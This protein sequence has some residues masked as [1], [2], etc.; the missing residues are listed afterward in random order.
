MYIFGPFLIFGFARSPPLPPP[1][2]LAS[3]PPPTVAATH[4]LGGT[5]FVFLQNKLKGRSI[6]GN[7]LPRRRQ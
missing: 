7:T 1:R 4:Q 6:E 5:D 3:P 2:S